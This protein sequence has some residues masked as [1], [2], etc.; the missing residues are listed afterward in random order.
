MQAGSGREAIVLSP[1][2]FCV[3]GRGRPARGGHSSAGVCVQLQFAHSAS[4]TLM[5]I[6]CETVRTRERD[7]GRMWRP[8]AVLGASAKFTALHGIFIAPRAVRV[9]AGAAC[10][11][12]PQS[13]CFFAALPT[14]QQLADELPTMTLAQV[15]R[16][17]SANADKQRVLLALLPE[18]GGYAPRRLRGEGRMAVLLS[19]RRRRRAD[20][21]VKQ[22]ET[23]S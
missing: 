23:G 11:T 1:A 5:T 10:N 13:R 18:A 15:E 21:L 14:A 3:L 17:L 19:W 12:Q 7:A 6:P 16:A 4:L 22:D 2:A 9:P 8:P 20:I